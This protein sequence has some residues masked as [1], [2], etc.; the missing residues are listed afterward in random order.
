LESFSAVL[1]PVGLLDRF[2]V[3]GVFVRWWDAVQFD[4]R[5]L[6]A[7]GYDGVLDGWVTT[8]VTAAEDAQSKT[9]PFD[10][11]L[12]RA[13][14]A[15]FL[16]ELATVEAQRAELDAKIKAATAPVDQGDED[17]GEESTDTERLSPAELISL[18]RELTRVRRRHRELTREIVTRLEKARAELTIAEVRDLVLRLTYDL[19]AEHLAEYITLSISRPA[20]SR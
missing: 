17:A 9:D 19:L 15:D 6:A 7:N 10:H 4:L 14:L 13:L 18:K 11:R 8:I 5:T 1:T 16:D 2:Q 12:V 20:V 3:A